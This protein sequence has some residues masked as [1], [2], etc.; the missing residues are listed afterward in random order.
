MALSKQQ[1]DGLER[2]MRSRCV[3]LAEEIRVHA[4]NRAEPLAPTESG[5]MDRGDVALADQIADLGDAESARDL[6]ELR[7]LEAALSR[8]ATGAFGHCVDCHE[9]IDEQRLYAQPAALRCLA[10][11]NRYDGTHAGASTPSL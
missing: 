4:R 2:T 8:M 1:L 10:C 3:T 11:Q 5:G 9:A 6:G 7:E